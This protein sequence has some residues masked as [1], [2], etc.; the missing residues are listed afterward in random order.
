VLCLGNFD[1]LHLG[2]QALLRRVAQLAG[3]G[4]QR[5]ALTFDPHPQAL[6]APDLKMRMLVPPPR[7]LELLAQAGLDL[8]WVLPFNRQLAALDAA[9]F[10]GGVLAPLAPHRL[11]L[12][13]DAR[14]GAERAAGTEELAR[15]AQGFGFGL[16]VLE[17]L[18]LEG[19]RVSST[20]IRDKLAAGDLP[21]A[22]RLLGRWFRVF[23]RVGRG[24]G[25]GRSMGF[26]TANLELEEQLSPAPG[27][28]LVRAGLPSGVW[29]PGLAA[30]GNRPTFGDSEPSF[31]VF[32][33]DYSGDLYG[34][35]LIVDMLVR[36]RDLRAFGSV[37]ELVAAMQQDL[38]GARAFFAQ[39]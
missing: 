39:G 5:V 2:H 26:P 17:G 14:L 3:T 6:L 9:G 10:L 25:L 20:A 4:R 33:L 11:V 35:E 27:V 32:L 7:R 34:Q 1:G 37:E 31:E 8:L 29:V 16:E 12:G 13:E 36:L 15:L 24:R 18:C 21:G 28:Y 38:V 30:I 19:Q 22:A 23:G